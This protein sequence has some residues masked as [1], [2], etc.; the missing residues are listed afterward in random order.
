M[1]VTIDGTTGVSLVQ[2]GVIQTADLA[3][4]AVTAAKVAAGAVTG[5]ILQTQRHTVTTHNEN[6]TTTYSDSLLTVNITPSSTSSKILVMSHASI[7]FFRG[8]DNE[9][10]GISRLVR[11][12][13]GSLTQLASH[14]FFE[15]HDALGNSY[16]LSV[17]TTDNY[18]VLDSPSSTNELTYKIQIKII[19]ANAIRYTRHYSGDNENPGEIVVMELGQ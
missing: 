3:D 18:F 14:S 1:A 6:S 4:D 19:D 11:V 17:F 2:D 8:N 7:Q 10:G 9:T 5:T 12:D 13:D 15:S 16:A